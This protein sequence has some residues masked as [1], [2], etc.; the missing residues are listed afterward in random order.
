EPLVWPD[1]AR[2]VYGRNFI[3]QTSSAIS[4]GRIRG[5]RGSSL[6]LLNRTV[7]DVMDGSISASSVRVG[8]GSSVYGLVGRWAPRSLVSWIMGIRRVDELSTWKTSSEGERSDREEGDDDDDD[9]DDGQEEAAA[10]AASSPNNNN[11][12]IELSSE[13]NVWS[14]TP[15]DSSIWVPSMPDDSPQ[16]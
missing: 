9:D 14:A 1:G 7:F 10:A 11:D 3:A 8:L 15:A 13:R 16:P 4:G 12:F 6:R 5:L 2:H